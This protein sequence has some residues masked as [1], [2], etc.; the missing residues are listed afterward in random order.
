MDTNVWLR[1]SQPDHQQYDE[2]SRAT[3]LLQEGGH[4]LAVVP[5]VLY[6]FWVV[7]TRAGAANG[8]E[9]S[10]SQASADVDDILRVGALYADD[11]SILPWWRLLVRRHE[12]LGKRAHDAR[13]VAAML[14]HGITHLLTFN[15]RD[16]ARFGDIIVVNPAEAGSVPPAAD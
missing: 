2:A 7:A 14:R 5:Q 13:L 12:V 11:S 15:A 8:I 4:V 1:A 9:L 16:F 10:A 6:E 3:V